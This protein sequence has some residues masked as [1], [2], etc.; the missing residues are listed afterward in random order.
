MQTTVFLPFNGARFCVPTNAKIKPL[1]TG[2]NPAAGGN[3]TTDIIPLYGQLAIQKS[4]LPF[5]AFLRC[6]YST[7]YS[8]F[9]SGFFCKYRLTAKSARPWMVNTCV[10]S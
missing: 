9:S 4:A 2:K 3:G 8:P 1:Y 7:V 5:G 10:F 6:Y